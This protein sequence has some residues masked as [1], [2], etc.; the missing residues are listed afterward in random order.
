MLAKETLKKNIKKLSL[1]ITAGD[2][3]YPTSSNTY[4]QNFVPVFPNSRP[5]KNLIRNFSNVMEQVL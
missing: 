4:Q 3:Y 5:T 2:R 1:C